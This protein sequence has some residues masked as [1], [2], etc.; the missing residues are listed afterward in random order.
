MTIQ[1]AAPLAQ[2]VAQLPPV[3]GIA[4]LELAHADGVNVGVIEHKPGKTLS[5]RIYNY[6]HQ[7]HGRIDAA[8]AR[9][10]LQLF[11]DYVAEART[12]PGAHPNIDRL[13][14]I[15]EGG[16]PLTVTVVREG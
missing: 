11:G 1:P 3:D 9:G 13:I 8:A 2:T 4:R 12:S 6:L 10:G 14:A 16:S 7:M 15:A 5:L